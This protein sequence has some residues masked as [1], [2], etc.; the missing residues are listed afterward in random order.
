MNETTLQTLEFDK[1]KTAVAEYAVSYAGRALAEGLAPSSRLHQVEAWLEETAEAKDLLER[2]SSIPLPLL[3]GIEWVMGHL[4]KGYVLSAEDLTAVGTLLQS[5]GQ[6]RRFMARWESVA[7]TVSLYAR[8]IREH[9]GLREEIE[10]S[11]RHG[12]ITDAASPELG[13]L[14]RQMLVVEERLK[15][16]LDTV[17][18]K[19][20]GVL[21]ETIVSMRGGRYV[22]PV[23]K[24]H[25]KLVPGTVLDQSSSGQTV[26]IEPA[27]L[28]SLQAEMNGLRFEESAEEQKVLAVLTGLVEA[29]EPELRADLEIVGHYDFLFA[30]AKYA[31]VIGGRKPSVNEDGVI[32]MTG[33][34]HPLLGGRM[35]PIDFAIGEGC[36]ALVVTG[37]NTGGKTVVLKTVGLLTLM[38][39]SGLLPPADEGSAFSL[40]RSVCADIGDGQSLEQSLS[41]F[42]AHVKQ[43]IGILAIADRRT[44]VLLDELASG[45]DPG[46]GIGLAIAVLEE[47]GRRGATIV[48]TTHYNEIKTFAARTPGFRNARMEF[49]ADTLEPLYRLTIGEAGSSYAL[50]IARKLGMDARIVERSG[51]I[52]RG[53][54][55]AGS[56]SAGTAAS[57]ADGD[58]GG[59]RSGVEASGGTEAGSAAQAAGRSAGGAGVGAAHG[60][61]A[62]G[63]SGVEAGGGTVSADP[64]GAAR[65]GETGPSAGRSKRHFAVGDCVYIHPLNRTGIVYR[66]A[67]DRGMVIV[68]VQEKKLKFNAKRLSLH[69]PA[70]KLYPGADYDLDIVFESVEARKKR[71]LM[72]R[73]HAEGVTLEY[74]PEE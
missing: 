2:S 43:L 27:E 52:A 44:L 62:G 5:L 35:V 60:A 58:G 46:E 72:H 22:I 11:I 74:K 47:L 65:G 1:I 6:L 10:R 61:G 28:A 25:R 9:A 32:R 36:R 38:A 51:E 26:Y 73:K 49:D 37:P 12:R 39:Q 42:S 30:K 55:S 13:K 33:A 50:L 59:G 66:P 64:R 68:Q 29:V 45:T 71:K 16:K 17:L 31:C 53:A 57:A 19:H 54:G 48:A 4:G 23:K 21:Q 69:I 56:V 3:E 63:R 67:D 15:K 18:Q 7:G 8:A 70:E 20:K 14:R 40:Y 41:T 34:K 24:E